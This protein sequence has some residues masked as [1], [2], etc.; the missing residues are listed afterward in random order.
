LRDA[1]RIIRRI[2]LDEQFIRVDHFVVEHVDGGNLP[3]DARGDGNH[4]RGDE[5]VVG[6]FVR[7]RVDQIIEPEKQEHGQRAGRRPHES[8]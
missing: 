1:G 8:W 5:S 6:G 3:G 7:E 4:V 2:D